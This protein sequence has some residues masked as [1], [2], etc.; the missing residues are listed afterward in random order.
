MTTETEGYGPGGPSVSR[1]SARTG[2]RPV[3]RNQPSAAVHH[4]AEKRTEKA[5]PRRPGR[6]R[7]A[8]RAGTLPDYRSGV[9]QP[10]RLLQGLAT[11]AQDGAGDD[12]AL[13]LARALVDLRD[14]GVP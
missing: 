3:P 11:L 6:R 5:S 9:L 7:G 8:L 13:D 14:P 12:E 1:S 4:A 2:T 10:A